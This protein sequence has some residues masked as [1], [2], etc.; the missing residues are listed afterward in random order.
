MAQQWS[1]LAARYTGAGGDMHAF[2]QAAATGGIRAT[3]GT[4][5]L[6]GE[7]GCWRGLVCHLLLEAQRA[8]GQCRRTCKLSEV[9][10]YRIS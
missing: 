10:M 3:A 1:T 9:G 6:Q 8:C 5:I 4:M 2:M 7:Q